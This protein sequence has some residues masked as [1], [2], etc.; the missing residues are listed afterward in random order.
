MFKKYIIIIFRNRKCVWILIVYNID[1]LYWI[2]M[3]LEFGVWYYNIEFILGC[4]IGIKM[5]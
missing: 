3:S 1:V 4:K 5:G 2:M